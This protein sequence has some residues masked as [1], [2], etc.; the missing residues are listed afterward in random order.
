MGPGPL[1]DGAR[2]EWRCGRR[3]AVRARARSRRVAVERPA[4]RPPRGG[5]GIL[6]VQRP[7]HRGA[8]S[9]SRRR[10]VRADPRSRRTLRRR[11]GIPHRGC[12]G[13]FPDRCLGLS[14]GPLRRHRARLGRRRQERAGV[15]RCH[16]RDAR[17][18]RREWARVR[19]VPLQRRDGSL[20]AL[21]D[22]RAAGHRRGHPRRARANGLRVVQAARNAGRVR[23]RGRVHRSRPESGQAR[24]AASPDRLGRRRDDRR[25]RRG[26]AGGIS[27]AFPRARTWSWAESGRGPRVPGRCDGLP[28]CGGRNRSGVLELSCYQIHSEIEPR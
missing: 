11:D 19:P 8:G 17:E 18:S 7:G 27:R 9:D 10:P 14:H 13:H 6:H 12:A 21:F 16:T 24:R 26:P 28:R 22:R 5:F 4:P 15:P 23:A 20:R 25:E 3:C 1:A 2:V